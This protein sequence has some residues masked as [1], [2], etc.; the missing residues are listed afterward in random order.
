MRVDVV[1]TAAVVDEEAD[2]EV[3]FAA[4]GGEGVS[5]DEEANREVAFAAAVGECAGDA[6][7]GT[8]GADVLLALMGTDEDIDTCLAAPFCVF[9]FIA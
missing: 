9:V 3:A 7:A 8:D 4:A 6:A 1:A 5:V 2:R